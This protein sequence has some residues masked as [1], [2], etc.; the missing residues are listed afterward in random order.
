MVRDI[1]LA[2]LSV[3]AFGAVITA[4]VAITRFVSALCNRRS[5]RRAS[6]RFKNRLRENSAPMAVET[7]ELAS[8]PESDSG[9]M[10]STDRS[11]PFERQG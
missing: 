2:L 6:K 10:P 3:T 7:I 5:H 9:V 11:D 8:F 1:E 4:V